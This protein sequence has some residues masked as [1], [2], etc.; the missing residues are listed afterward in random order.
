VK[1]P[2]TRKTATAAFSEAFAALAQERASEFR[3]ELA[4]ESNRI[5]TAFYDA[6]IQAL[7]EALSH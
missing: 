4:D 7:D 2:G 3:R 1:S 5:A 6:H